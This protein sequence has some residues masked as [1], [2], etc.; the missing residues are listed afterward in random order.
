VV[1]VPAVI[2]VVDAPQLIVAVGSVTVAGGV[3]FKGTVAVAVFVHPFR[4]L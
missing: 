2:V 3:T 1:D 4:V